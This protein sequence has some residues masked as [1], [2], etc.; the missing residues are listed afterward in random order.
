MWRTF[1]IV[2]KDAPQPDSEDDVCVIEKYQ[3]ETASSETS[4]SLLPIVQFLS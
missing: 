2:R 1:L 3:H 4:Y